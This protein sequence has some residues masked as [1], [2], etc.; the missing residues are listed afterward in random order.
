M[1]HHRTWNDVGF[2]NKGDNF[3]N[4]VLKLLQKKNEKTGEK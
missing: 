3:E 1:F 4:P 2:F